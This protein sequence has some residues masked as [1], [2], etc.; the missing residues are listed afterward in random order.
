MGML[1]ASQTERALRTCPISLS[2]MP[3]N[4]RAQELYSPCLL[5]WTELCGE[6]LTSL[7]LWPSRSQNWTIGDSPKRSNVTRTST[8][9]STKPARR[10]RSWRTPYCCS[11]GSRLTAVTDSMRPTFQTNSPAL[12]CSLATVRGF[13]K[14]TGGVPTRSLVAQPRPTKCVDMLS[15]GGVM[16]PASRT[17][18]ARPLSVA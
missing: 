10:S 17:I 18:R 11:R 6:T 16:S 12:K 3:P 15:R 13:A 8:P 4:S 7:E 14:N 2:Y 5:G 9:T 1:P